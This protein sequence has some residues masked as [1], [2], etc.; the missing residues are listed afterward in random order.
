MSLGPRIS[1]P[2]PLNVKDC[3]WQGRGC[4]DGGPSRVSGQRVSEGVRVSTLE[5]RQK[6]GWGA[7]QRVQTQAS[8]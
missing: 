6:V 1:L 4:V 5:G 7:E 3:G 2:H 8:R